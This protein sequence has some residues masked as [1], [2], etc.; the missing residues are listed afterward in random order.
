MAI[1]CS[2]RA[3]EADQKD[4]SKRHVIGATHTDGQHGSSLYLGD[5]GQLRLLAPDG[6]VLRTFVPHALR[7]RRKESDK[8]HV[9]YWQTGQNVDQ[10]GELRSP[11]DTYRLK[12]H[13]C[14]Q[15]NDTVQETTV[16][17]VGFELALYRL[18]NGNEKR[19]GAE[20]YVTS[21]VEPVELSDGKRPLHYHW[22]DCSDEMIKY[23]EKHVKEDKQMKVRLDFLAGGEV[24]GRIMSRKF[25]KSYD[26][27]I[28]LGGG[29]GTNA[30]F[31]YGA[32]AVKQLL[33]PS[34]A[35]NK[36]VYL[37]L[38]DDGSVRL[39]ARDTN[40]VLLVLFGTYRPDP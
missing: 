34:V 2:T 29:T 10:D 23:I 3:T 6:R 18:G 8:Y 33:A 15:P 32:K 39:H 40:D 31:I 21:L 11:N 27:T 17:R 38:S 5:D 14:R 7:L 25:E 28:I 36:G 12:L 4:P 16:W 9:N 1:S 30:R 19:V 20:Q 35:T 24:V 37:I 26:I 13:F 22:D